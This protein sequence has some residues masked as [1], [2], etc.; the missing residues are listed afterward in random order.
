M[1]LKGK[2]ETERFGRVES[3]VLECVYVPCACHSG[4]LGGCGFPAT[5]SGADAGHTT[6]QW[7]GTN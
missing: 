4:F 6:P 7:S 3:G 2:A 5:P 1:A